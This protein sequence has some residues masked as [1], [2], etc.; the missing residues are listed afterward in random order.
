MSS[1]S[2]TASPLNDVVAGYNGAGWAVGGYDVATGKGTPR[3][4]Q[5]FVQALANA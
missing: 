3:Q 1:S 2:S 4:A 5:L